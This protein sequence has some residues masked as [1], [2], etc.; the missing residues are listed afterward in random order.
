MSS[1]VEYLNRIPIIKSKPPILEIW[2]RETS[3]DI[4]RKRTDAIYEFFP[5]AIPRIHSKMGKVL[6][7]IRLSSSEKPGI[8]DTSIPDEMPSYLQLKPTR[9]RPEFEF[10]EYE[11]RSK[12]STR[13]K[14]LMKQTSIK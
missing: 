9:I 1:L 10:S 4:D 8:L 5:P 11:K 13:I 2:E 12:R 7:C 14:R 6:T 3:E